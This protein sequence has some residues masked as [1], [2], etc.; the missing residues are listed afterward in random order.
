PAGP[1][2]FFSRGGFSGESGLDRLKPGERRF[3]EFGN[4][5]DLTI[6]EEHGESR[7]ETKKIKATSSSLEEHYLRTGE[8]TYTVENRAG[9]PKRALVQL[10]CGKNSTVTGA[11]GFDYDA[12]AAHPMARLHVQP[13]S[14]GERKVTIVERLVRRT[15]L[16]EVTSEQLRHFL[17]N[18]E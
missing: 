11:D 16:G 1:I 3:L 5:L 7:E 2:A 15:S 17:E 6:D 18:K 8:I 4:D 12:I 14:K 9:R 10:A 13:R